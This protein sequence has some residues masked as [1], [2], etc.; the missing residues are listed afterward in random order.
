MLATVLV[1]VLLMDP[2]P[3]G[4]ADAAR[5]EAL[6][7]V[8]A[9]H[10]ER[11]T[12]SAER[13][14]DELHHAH[15]KFDAAFMVEGATAYLCRALAVADLA[16]RTGGFAD[17]QERLSWEETRE[18]DLARLREEAARRGQANCR[19]DARG[20]PARPR[21]AMLSED[22][23]PP[24]PPTVP[25]EPTSHTSGWR[26]VGP[27]RAQLR[28]GRAHTGAGALLTGAGVGM[29]GIFTGVLALER[30]R[31]TAMLELIN[32]ANAEKRRFTAA[33][34]RRFHA[35]ADDLIRGRDVA[36]GV[37]V[38]GVVSLGTGVALLATRKRARTR[39]YALHPYGGLHGAGAVLRL[40]F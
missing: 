8:G 3:V 29:L 20:E 11:A 26:P 15:T 18:D 34:D 6:A 23:I 40:K 16:L 28:R 4:A 25:S 13:P 9:A 19:Y 10:L 35:L 31:A 12:T 37:G 30:E 21:V 14:L 22:D 2:P 39:S 36:I 17:E 5:A 7:A 32:T 38:A 27:T 33:E 1:T 24:R